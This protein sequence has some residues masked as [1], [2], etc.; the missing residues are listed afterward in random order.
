MD[1]MFRGVEAKSEKAYVYQVKEL[2]S[3]PKSL[4]GQ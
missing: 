3:L 2:N 1:A 4:I